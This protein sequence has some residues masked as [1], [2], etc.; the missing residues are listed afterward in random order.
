LL[1][2]LKI[3]FVCINMTIVTIMLAFIMG[4]VVQFTKQNMEQSN[5]QM[6]ERLASNPLHLIKPLDNFS[7]RLPYF[8]L[9]LNSQGEFLE[10][11]SSSYDLS[12]RRI[13]D[14][15][16][17]ASY[18]VHEEHGILP[19]YNLQFMR[20][21]T[22]TDQFLIFVDI[23]G[24]IATIDQLIHTCI[25]IGLFSF[26]LFLG[27]S[28][29]LANWAV[30]PVDTA[31]KQQKQFVADA[32]HELKTPLTVIL[33][34]TELLSSD[35]TLLAPCLDNIKLVTEQMRNLVEGLLELS[36]MDCGAS[37]I[38]LQPLNFS[39]LVQSVV[40][41]FEPLYYESNVTLTEAI[42]KDII[43]KGSD[44]HL[45]QVIDILLDN[46]LKYTF[47]GTEVHIQLQKQRCFVLLSVTNHGTPIE[48]DDLTNIFKRFYRT[49]Q[50]RNKRGSY[51]LGL[52]IAESIVQEHHG[53]IWAESQN[54]I[55]TFYIRLPAH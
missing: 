50:S 26:V 16:L 36:R 13:L 30:K 3:K 46:A 33:T 21:N 24:D 15:I 34:N 11:L 40:C 55:N 35:P 9:R 52:S 20:I 7:V 45:R 38:S 17:D 4:M 51:G 41:I 48:P 12:D 18:L 2:K 28:I 31:W 44:C 43:L 23:S 27:I 8:S 29:L 53:K 14:R 32:S 5:L 42:E 19:E 49:E 6:M 54:G 39:R 47:S 37:R 22:P 10:A 1:K 25:G